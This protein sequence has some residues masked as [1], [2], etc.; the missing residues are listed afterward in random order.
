[1]TPD[2]HAAEAER[3]L[4]GFREQVGHDHLHLDAAK[5]HALLAT[6]PVVL[7]PVTSVDPMY[8]DTVRRVHEEQAR[9]AARKPGEAITIWGMTRAAFVAFAREQVASMYDGVPPGVAAALE[10]IADRMYP[11]GGVEPVHSAQRLPTIRDYDRAMKNAMDALHEAMP[12]HIRITHTRLDVLPWA[13]AA[14]DAFADTPTTE[15]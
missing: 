15:T 2:E 5:I 1:M 10:L 13:K 11:G 12:H 14:V 8:A 7:E 4:T 9:Q 6:R 3:I